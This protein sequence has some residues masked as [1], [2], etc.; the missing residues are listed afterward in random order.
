MTELELEL[1]ERVITEIERLDG[2]SQ[3]EQNRQR[4]RAL[5]AAIKYEKQL[6][7][8]KPKPKSWPR[9][10]AR[11]ILGLL[12]FLASAIAVAAFGAEIDLSKLKL[13]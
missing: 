1:Y 5:V 4:L 10:N 2:V 12:L 13:F 9:E 11:L 3:K 6:K 8:I 7:A